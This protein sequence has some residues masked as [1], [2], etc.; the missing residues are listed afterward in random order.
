M[1]D[2]SVSHG[3]VIVLHGWREGMQKILTQKLLRRNGVPLSVAYDAINS[4]LNGKPAEVLLRDGS[5]PEAVRQELN[6]L[7]VI[8]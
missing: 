6:E 1:S 5:D 2:K 8:A 4:I 3:P 7:G